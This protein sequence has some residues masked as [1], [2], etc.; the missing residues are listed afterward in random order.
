MRRPRFHIRTLM[1]I[2]GLVAVLL[3]SRA[4]QPPST[5]RK[6]LPAS[7]GLEASAGGFKMDI[8]VVDRGRI[9]VFGAGRCMNR[10]SG[11][12]YVWNL[13][14][15][16]VGK[17]PRDLE[18]ILDRND[19]GA[20]IRHPGGGVVLNPTFMDVVDLK[21]GKYRVRLSLYGIPPD[22]TPPG[23]GIPVDLAEQRSKGVH[24]MLSGLKRITID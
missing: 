12:W 24:R 23:V 6:A 17:T 9:A 15:E 14:V 21:P 13:Q 19:F 2:V 10:R 5:S 7:V 18:M 3:S 11:W 8:Q 16:V 4:A 22:F 20:A 1:I